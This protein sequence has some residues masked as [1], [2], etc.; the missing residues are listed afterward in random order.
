MGGCR[1]PPSGRAGPLEEAL[2]EIKPTADKG[3]VF[4]HKASTLPW[5]SE[6]SLPK[7]EPSVVFNALVCDR[8]SFDLEWHKA[9]GDE[10]IKVPDWSQPEGLTWGGTRLLSMTISAGA[11]G[12]QKY[13]EDQRYALVTDGGVT[14]LVWQRSGRLQSP[15]MMVPKFRV[16][17]MYCFVFSAG[18][19]KMKTFSGITGYNGWLKGR[20]E[21]DCKADF[22]KAQP[23]FEELV[24]VALKKIIDAGPDVTSPSHV[25]LR[26]EYMEARKNRLSNTT[27]S[28]KTFHSFSS[29]NSLED[30]AGDGE[31]IVAEEDL[32]EQVPDDD[33]LNGMGV[34]ELIC[35]A[36]VQSRGC[37]R[38]PAE[39]PLANTLKGQLVEGLRAAPSRPPS[40]GPSKRASRKTLPSMDM[41]MMT[42][43]REGSDSEGTFRDCGSDA[44]SYTPRGD[45]VVVSFDAPP[46][47]LQKSSTHLEKANVGQLID[48]AARYGVCSSEIEKYRGEILRRLRTH[49]DHHA[50]LVAPTSVTAA[51][52]EKKEIEEQSVKPLPPRKT[53]SQCCSSCSVM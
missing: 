39:G 10:D 14:T 6:T 43:Q 30:M 31:F 46:P 45:F 48:L 23:R 11:I 21:T 9:N 25:S 35:I 15:P 5:K 38:C 44:E 40:R 50:I 29:C 7:C 24:R 42:P 33:K 41:E 12:K 3:I 36:T 37:G 19:V 26:E 53:D 17:A 13:R 2:R 34:A 28:F 4:T 22:G 27:H 16:Q 18:E 32:N 49:R 20:L 8:S 47:E 51:T 52:K 1:L